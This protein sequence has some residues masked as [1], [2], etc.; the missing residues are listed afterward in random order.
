LSSYAVPELLLT[1]VFGRDVAPALLSWQLQQDYV[2]VAE[3]VEQQRRAGVVVAPGCWAAVS[4]AAG[5]R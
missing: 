2:A 3:G 1:G 4:S 5:M